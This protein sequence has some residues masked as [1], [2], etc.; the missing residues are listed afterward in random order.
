MHAIKQIRKYLEENPSSTSA[1]ALAEFVN[2]VTAER[3]F[4][5][6]GLYQLS[7]QEFDLALDLLRDW[8]FDR[9]YAGEEKLFK[10]APKRPAVVPS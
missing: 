6:A 10:V 8:R 4:S 2:A 3:E 5:L 9:H 1:D 7:Y